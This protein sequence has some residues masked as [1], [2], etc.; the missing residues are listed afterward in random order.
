MSKYFINFSPAVSN[1]AM[2]RMR[3]EMRH[4]KLHRQNDKAI[5]DLA[6]MWN[7]VLR[8]WI[9][10]IACSDSASVGMRSGC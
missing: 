8:D 4:W 7:P 5:D 6:R 10:L 9:Q 3:Q 2:P 1:E